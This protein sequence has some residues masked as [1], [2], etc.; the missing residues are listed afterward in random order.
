MFEKFLEK[1]HLKTELQEIEFSIDL[2]AFGNPHELETSAE[3]HYVFVD[4]QLLVIFL[5][6]TIAEREVIATSSFDNLKDLVIKR[7]AHFDMRKTIFDFAI[8]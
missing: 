3:V 4:E 6:L 8:Q 5:G 7:E 1:F 2:I